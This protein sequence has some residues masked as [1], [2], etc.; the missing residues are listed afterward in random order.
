MKKN[1]LSILLLSAVSGL[2]ACGGGD[3]TSNA[4]D[5]EKVQPPVDQGNN[6]PV[7]QGKNQNIDK[8]FD[9]NGIILD[10]KSAPIKNAKIA[11]S[12]GNI[13][14]STYSDQT[15]KY[16]LK[17]P[18]DFKYPEFISGTIIAEHYKP[19]TL[20]LSFK[21][22]NLYVDQSSNNPQLFQLKDNDVIFFNGLT[23]IHLGDD[24]FSGAVNSQFQV[25]ASGLKW[26]DSFIYSSD[27]KSKYNK[28]CVS[29]TGKGI[30]GTVSDS[31]IALVRQSGVVDKLILKDSNVSGDYS[32]S[33]YCFS[34]S[35]V[36][37]NEQVGVEVVSENGG[38]GYDDFEV[39]NIMGK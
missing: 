32:N 13:E 9:I 16:T 20:L 31:Y 15:G 23:V 10:E 3:E 27:K 19:T 26:K 7:Q 18:Q 30:Q 2:T 24:S 14:Y 22:K 21:N 12:L 29:M 8:S 1:L 25:Q 6:Q 5:Q 37:E 11:V 35:N 17:T 38:N 36:N 39:I 4:Q 34:L 33:E 28:F